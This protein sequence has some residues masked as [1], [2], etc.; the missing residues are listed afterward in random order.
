[1]VYALYL[2]LV[3]LEVHRKL[4]VFDHEATVDSHNQR[5]TIVDSH[6]QRLTQSTIPKI[7]DYFTVIYTKATFLVFDILYQNA[8]LVRPQARQ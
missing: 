8:F 1:M 6:N 4:P 7:V 2:I 3:L 5:L